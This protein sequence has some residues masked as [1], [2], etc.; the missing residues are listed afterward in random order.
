M[1]PGNKPYQPPS[2][3]QPLVIFI[4]V[5]LAISVLAGV[6]YGL[7]RQS[8]PSLPADSSLQTTDDPQVAP[9]SQTEPQPGVIDSSPAISQAD[10]EKQIRAIIQHALYDYPEF[11]DRT[12][13]NPV[14]ATIG[15]YDNRIFEVKKFL[16]DPDFAASSE[17]NQNRID[18]LR[19]NKSKYQQLL[20]TDD[21]IFIDDYFLVRLQ[22]FEADLKKLCQIPKPVDFDFKAQILIDDLARKAEHR[23]TDND[24]KN[25]FYD[26]PE[27]GFGADFADFV[28]VL[29]NQ[30]YQCLSPTDQPNQG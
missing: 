20:N 17:A 18:D 10:H 5:F 6:I 7:S 13:S 12:A 19:Y 24:F 11:L 15:N 23:T 22:R 1:T 25:R 2:N 16:N 4:G 8:D 26:R 9:D 3:R 30:S 29:V 28:V 21:F 14:Y 27:S